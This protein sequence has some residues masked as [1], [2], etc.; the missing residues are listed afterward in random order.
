M[1]GPE[2]SV[3]PFLLLVASTFGGYTLMDLYYK[4]NEMNDTFGG[5]KKEIEDIKLVQDSQQDTLDEH[6]ECLREKKDYDESSEVEEGKFQAWKGEASQDTLRM[7]ILIWRVKMSSIQKNQEWTAWDGAADA[8]S[9]GRDFYLGNGNPEFVWKESENH[10]E[11]DETLINGWDSV[12]RI[13]IVVDRDPGSNPLDYNRLLKKY[14]ND[15][16]I[17]WSRVLIPSS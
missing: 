5:M 4:W 7:K 8:S 10:V 15:G 3:W 9:I 12:I 2:T 13:S 11:V 14:V 17:Q 6:S 1:P 16:S